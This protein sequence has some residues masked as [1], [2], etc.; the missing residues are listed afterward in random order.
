MPASLKEA[1]IQ[2]IR[3]YVQR[4]DKLQGDPVLGNAL[5]SESPD[6]PSESSTGTSTSI[7]SK[8]SYLNDLKHT[9]NPSKRP[10]PFEL[11]RH[12]NLLAPFRVCINT[13]SQNEQYQVKFFFFF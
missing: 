2:M 13:L 12:A 8:T 1:S 3:P 6:L 4:S 7:S 9:L 5:S 11:H 10:N